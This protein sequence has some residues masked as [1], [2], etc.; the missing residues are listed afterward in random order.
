MTDAPVIP[1]F[2][3]AAGRPTKR[4]KASPFSLRLTFEERARLER[5]A[6]NLPL[7]AYI[8]LKAL[9][10]APVPE[11]QTRS[12]RAVRDPEAMGQLLALLGRARLAN[13]L[14]QLAHAANTGSLPV[15][16]DT[17]T[18]I[19]EACAEVAFMRQELL[20]ALGQRSDLQGSEG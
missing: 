5:E 14:N 2:S 1:D 10:G 15:T 17:L 16:P 7:G 12:C 6:G 19:R 13:N 4:K 8:K 18:A 20:R 9:S 3:E 11:Y